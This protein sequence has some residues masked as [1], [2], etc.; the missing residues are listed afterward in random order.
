MPILTTFEHAYLTQAD[1]KNPSDF[2]WLLEQNFDG[3][4]IERKNQ[5]WRVKV[6]HYIGVIGLPSGEQLE[7]LPKISQHTDILSTR[8]WLQQMLKDIW[9]TLTPK[10]LNNLAQQHPIKPHLPLNQ[11]LAEQFWQRFQTYQPN[12]QYQRFEQ[13]QPFLQGKLLVKQQLQHNH[14]KPHKFFHQSENFAFDT[15]SNRLVK[16][17][18]ERMINGFQGSSYHGLGY[19]GLSYQGL[20][21]EWQAVQILSPHLYQT[22]FYQA[23]QECHALPSR[24]AQQNLLFLDFCYALLT[25]QQ[26]AGQGMNASQSLLIN[27][28]FA[29]EK[30]VTLKI[31]Q[32]FV[33]AQII[34]QKSQPLTA[35]N[36]LTLKPDIWLKDDNGV[37]VFD[38]K[39]KNIQSI[40][41]ISLADMYQLMMYASEFDAHEAWLVVPTLEKDKLRQAIPLA[42]KNRCKFYLVPFCVM[43]GVVS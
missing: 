9:Q 27:M 41:D 32:Q 14:H 11:W 18:F 38:I 36:L 34:A 37:Q 28:Q 20:G 8:Q 5:Q 22:T 33:P 42:R 1:F 3:F 4:T 40:K 16:T 15:A 39:W 21:Y 12:Q 6:S 7:I 43:S 35:D 31:Q 2:D 23:Q 17:T 10:A 29:F 13:N 25:L 26:G 24:I 30:W 19:Q